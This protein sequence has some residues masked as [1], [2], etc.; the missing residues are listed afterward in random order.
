MARYKISIDSFGKQRD[1]II[2]TMFRYVYV[3]K[4]GQTVR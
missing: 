2:L 3:Y 1:V 4:E